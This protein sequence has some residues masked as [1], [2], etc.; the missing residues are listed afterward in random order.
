MS[1]TLKRRRANSQNVKQ[2]GEI[3]I[4]T[5]HCSDNFGAMLQAYGLKHYLRKNGV[6]A[7]IVNYAPFFMTGRHWWLPYWPQAD[8]WSWVR[9]APIMC[10]ELCRH[11]HIHR[12]FAARRANM[13]RFRREYLIDARQRKVRFSPGLWRLPYRIYIVGSDQIWNPDITFGLRKVYFGSFRNSRKER[14]IAYAASLGGI[15]LPS[16][17]DR[18]FAR[19]IQNLDAVSLREAE[20]VPYVERFYRKKIPALLD[21]VFLLEKTTWQ[22]IE[23]LPHRKD[24]ILVYA[25][26]KNSYMSGCACELSR[27]TGLPVVELG[28]VRTGVSAAVDAI[29]GP[30]EFL[31]YM[32]NAAYVVTNS[33]HATAFSILYQKC[34]LTFAHSAVNCRILDLLRLCG[35]EDRLCQTGG[36]IDSSVDWGAVQERIALESEKSRAFLRDNI[37]RSVG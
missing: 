35:L 1:N 25:T 4:L 17:Y 10:L 34:F 32:H 24:Y 20:A 8:L 13:A 18:K 37:F 14:V 28:E 26:E 16:Q 27:K 5:F 7:D 30:A 23:R 21:P 12:E 19:L 31:G 11:L 15:S 36:D 2:A 33:F 22:E 3:G 29:A 9:F 6:Q